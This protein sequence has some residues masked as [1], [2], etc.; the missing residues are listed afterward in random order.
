MK[1]KTMRFQIH[2]SRDQNTLKDVGSGLVRPQA[3]YIFR[4]ESERAA[5]GSAF[6]YS[7]WSC[8][9]KA[10]GDEGEANS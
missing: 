3:M 8:K 4:P 9:Q 10:N 1:I 7:E 2:F 5:A 6:T